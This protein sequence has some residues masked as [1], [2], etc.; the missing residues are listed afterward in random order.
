MLPLKEI[1][2]P[3]LIFLIRDYFQIKGESTHKHVFESSNIFHTFKKLDV[4]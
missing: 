4:K 1:Y 3:I 2:N